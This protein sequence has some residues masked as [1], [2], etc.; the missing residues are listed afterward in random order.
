MERL[1]SDIAKEYISNTSYLPKVL[2]QLA[3]TEGPDG[4]MV[5]GGGGGNFF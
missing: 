5:G 3:D 4:G 1:Y 2:V